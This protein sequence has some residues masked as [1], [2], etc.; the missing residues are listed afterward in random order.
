M[1]I[2]KKHGLPNIVRI[3]HSICIYVQVSNARKGPFVS[4]KTPIIIADFIMI[5]NQIVVYFSYAGEFYRINLVGLS[6]RAVLILNCSLLLQDY[7]YIF[8]SAALPGENRNCN[9][10]TLFNV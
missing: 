7:I 10:K 1:H 9:D 3:I 5:G 8:F 4:Y 2:F 6:W